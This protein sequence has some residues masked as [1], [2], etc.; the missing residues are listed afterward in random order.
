MPNGRS[1]GFEIVRK[2]LKSILE[3]FP[4]DAVVGH[5]IHTSMTA[6][7]ALALVEKHGKTKVG[8]EEQD[9]SWYIAHLSTWIVVGRSSPLY[10]SFRRCHARWLEDRAHK[11]LDD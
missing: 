7:E 4:N 9:G 6:A 10:E 1:G 5:S 3:S 11:N 2:E 8:I